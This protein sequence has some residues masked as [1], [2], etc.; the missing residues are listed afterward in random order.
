M[1]LPRTLNRLIKRL[2]LEPAVH[3]STPLQ[4]RPVANATL[5]LGRSGRRFSCYPVQ[6]CH[7]DN[8]ETQF[9]PIFCV[10]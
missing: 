6:L 4:E 5:F 8:R 1:Y 9:A 3:N 10:I 2:F 7:A